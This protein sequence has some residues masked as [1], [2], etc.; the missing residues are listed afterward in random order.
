M[1]FLIFLGVLLILWLSVICRIVC[2]HPVSTIMYAV[3]DF[4]FGFGI[5]VIISMK[6]AF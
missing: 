1:G 2:L 6:Q 5:R 3:K 4:Y